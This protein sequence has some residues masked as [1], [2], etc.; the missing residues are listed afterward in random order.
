M[1]SFQ[2][3]RG[4]VAPSGTNAT[5]T[6]PAYTG[7]PVGKFY[8]KFEKIFKLNF[9]KITVAEGQDDCSQYSDSLD[10]C[11][12]DN[13]YQCGQVFPPMPGSRVLGGNF[14]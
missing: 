9:V 14:T 1:V 13:G 8:Q 2:P 11:C 6:T 12:P 7:M 3:A 10:L 4:T 5:I